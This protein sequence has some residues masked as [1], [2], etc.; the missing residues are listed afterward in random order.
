M[1]TFEEDLRLLSMVSDGATP[2]LVSTTLKKPVA[3]CF[4]HLQLL[5]EH[6]R[7]YN[8]ECDVREEGMQFLCY[9]LKF[10]SQ[11]CYWKDTS[12]HSI[13]QE[14]DKSYNDH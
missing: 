10:S 1:W 5:K 11:A 14:E 13:Y 3:K 6:H 7:R 2:N 4:S 8:E 9:V 12:K